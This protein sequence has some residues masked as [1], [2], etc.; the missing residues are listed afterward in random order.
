M[1]SL[2][3]LEHD[4]AAERR[5]PEA[6]AR[7]DRLASGAPLAV[8]FLGFPVWWALGLA[9]LI[10][11][12]VAVPMLVHLLRCR[13][14]RVPP[15]FGVW[16]LFLA[17][18]AAGVFLVYA[19]APGTAPTRGIA[20]LI[21]FGVR[22]FWYLTATIAMLYVL[23]TARTLSTQRVTRL[24]GIM[25]IITAAFGNLAILAPTLEFTS[26]VELALPGPLEQSNFVRTLVHP[27]VA[28]SSDFLGYEQP[29]PTAPFAYSNAWGNNLALYLPFFV[30]SWF[31]PQAGWRRYVAPLVLLGAVPPVVSSLNRGLWIAIGLA[32]VYVAV[33]LA[34]N[35]RGRALQLL[36]VGVVVAGVVFVFSPLYDTARTRVETPHSNERRAS[37]AQEVLAATAQGSPV[38]GYGTTRQKL[39]SFGS[40][41]GG[42]TPDCRQCAPPPLGTQGFM[43]RLVLTTGFVGTVLCLSFLGL[44]FLRRA[45]GPSL[46]D[47]TG[48]ATLLMGGVCFFVYDSLGSALVTMMIAIGLMAR[49]RTADPA[50]AAPEPQR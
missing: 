35:G 23:N 40:L 26:L 22:Y 4:S 15:G 47:I 7:P 14:V 33:R 42:A 27:E 28:S 34:V 6:P 29:R 41:A 13:T 43:W 48:C 9:Q 2:H 10:F 44:Q 1:T 24:L 49:D 12:L 36:A 25:F 11:F 17:W 18:T 39:G 32:A 5:P 8:L 3:G 38:V 46:L 45:R 16:L 37:I 31:G 30:Y 20:P 50:Q 19:Q 21:G